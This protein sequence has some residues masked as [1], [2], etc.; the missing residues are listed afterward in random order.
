MIIRFVNWFCTTIAIV[1]AIAGVYMAVSEKIPD[2]YAL[3]FFVI[4]AIV[5]LLGRGIVGM[6]GRITSGK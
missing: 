2:N 1:L 3:P 4:A 5:V 6:L